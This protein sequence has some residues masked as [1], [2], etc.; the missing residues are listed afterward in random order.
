MMGRRKKSLLDPSPIDYTDSKY[1]D[2]PNIFE[3]EETLKVLKKHDPINVMMTRM[4]LK[5]MIKACEKQLGF[6]FP[7]PY[8]DWEA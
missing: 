6:T 7:N 5:W 1:T 8:R 2:I 4:Q 3:I